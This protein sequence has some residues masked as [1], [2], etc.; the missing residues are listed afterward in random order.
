MSFKPIVL[1]I[2]SISEVDKLKKIIKALEKE[3]VDLQSN[4]G[5]VTLEKENLRLNL[6][7]KRGR[8]LK[9]DNDVQAEQHKRRKV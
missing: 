5:K 9:A 2:V 1:P 8:S 7:Q 4:L 6:N 3:N